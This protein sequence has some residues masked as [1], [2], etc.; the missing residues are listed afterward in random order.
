MTRSAMRGFHPSTRTAP[1]KVRF[2]TSP[3]SSNGSKW[4]VQANATTDDETLRCEPLPDTLFEPLNG[5]DTPS[6]GSEAL[7]VVSSAFSAREDGSP[8]PS[9]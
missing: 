8:P 1:A 2:D 6:S 5:E 7:S 4:S 3:T 9:P